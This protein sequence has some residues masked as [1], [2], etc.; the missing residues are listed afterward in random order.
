MEGEGDKIKSKQDSKRDRSLPNFPGHSD[1]LRVGTPHLFGHP[2]EERTI[3]S[4]PSFP[5]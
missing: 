2:S 1:F 3:D 4:P 5:S